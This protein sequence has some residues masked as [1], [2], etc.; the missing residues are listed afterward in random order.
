MRL[1][2]FSDFPSRV[3]GSERPSSPAPIARRYRRGCWL[4]VAPEGELDILSVPLLPRYLEGRS[5]YVVFDLGL[6]TFIDASFLNFLAE[7][8]NERGRGR[9]AVRVANPSPQARRLLA[10]TSLDR[11]LAVFESLGHA[12][13]EARA[14]GPVGADE[15]VLS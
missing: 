6:V 1:S 14:S 5:S 8:V 13:A 11:K 15:R 4:V 12:L 2:S 7:T 3:G 10:L 9:G